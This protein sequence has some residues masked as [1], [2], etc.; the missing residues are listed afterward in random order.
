M[1]ARSYESDN[2][3][4]VLPLQTRPVSDQTTPMPEAKTKISS[5]RESTPTPVSAPAPEKSKKKKKKKGKSESTEVVP[6]V[7]TATPVSVEPELSESDCYGGPSEWKVV[8]QK[9]AM[10]PAFTTPFVVPEVKTK[11][12]KKLLDKLQMKFPTTPLSDEIRCELYRDISEGDVLESDE[13]YTDSNSD[14][15]ATDLFEDVSPSTANLTV[16]TQGQFDNHNDDSLPASPLQTD[17]SQPCPICK[18]EHNGEYLPRNLQ[19][20]SSKSGIISNEILGSE[21]KEVD[22]FYGF[23]YYDLVNHIAT[24]TNKFYKESVIDVRSQ[25]SELNQ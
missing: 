14:H 1:A 11:N 4:G 2:V 5:S 12:K 6:E 8:I 22:T 18:L 19:F 17:Q 10:K 15:E 3:V 24:E 23:F 16:S 25:F 20:D 21:W 13:E 7:R 9:G